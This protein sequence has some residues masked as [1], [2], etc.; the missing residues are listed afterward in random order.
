MN[1]EGWA[2]RRLGAWP[3][4]G[5]FEFRVWAPD[6]RVCELILEETGKALRL[7]R[8]SRDEY[9]IRVEGVTPGTLYR[10]R[11][12]GRG[13][14]PDPASRSQPKGVHGPS[15]T[16][17]LAAFPWRQSSWNVPETDRLVVVELHVGT[18]TPEG[19]FDALAGRLPYYAGLGVTAVE[20]MPVAGFPGA[21][22]WGYDGVSLYAPSNIYGGVRGLQRFVD[23]AHWLGLAVLLDVVYNHLGPDGNYLGLYSSGYFTAAQTP[24]GQAVDFGNRPV[25]DFFLGNALMWVHDYRVDGLRFDA[26]HAMLVPGKPHILEELTRRLRA[27]VGDSRR[28]LLIAEDGSNEACLVRPPS[29]GGFG[30]DAVWADDLH[31]HL[32]VAATGERDGYYTDYRGLPEEIARTLRRGWFF[33]GQRSDYSGRSRG[34][35]SSGL[36]ASSF[37]HCLQNHDQ[38][39]NRAMGERLHHLSGLEVWRAL[40]TL[41]LLDPAVPLLFMGQEWACSSPFLY[42]TDH[43]P[44]LGHLVTQ[45]RRREFGRFR[46]FRSARAREQIPD[47]QSAET[48][49]TSKLD[50]QE[51]DRAPHS[52]V[53]ALYRELL[54]LRRQTRGPAGSAS[55]AFAASKLGRRGLAFRRGGGGPAVLAVVNLGGTLRQDLRALRITRP[56]RGF[57]WALMLS[58]E[59]DRFGGSPDH[60]E[61]SAASARLTIRGPAAAVLRERP[62]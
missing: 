28:L 18:A 12:D 8:H 37:V 43:E 10:Y 14:F 55:A 15:E 39:G 31:H 49:L 46:G 51:A 9:A 50:W 53:L 59:E 6:V 17:D 23:E 57:E 33:E 19:T 32:H 24:W 13:P 20:L 45:G 22:N 27:S 29:E 56:R 30:L 1:G 60:V 40:S 36:A 2:R 48:F 16:C 7:V 21:R 44:A 42:F 61:L 41:L 25:R 47:P 4:D 52:G 58:S 11:L 35:R 3:I 34:T 26:T 5:G 54:Q 38:A 62:V